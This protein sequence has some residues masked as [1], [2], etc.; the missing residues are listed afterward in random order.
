MLEFPEVLNIS[1]QLQETVVGKTVRSVLPP[2]KRHKFC[3]FNGDPADYEAKIAGSKI[4]SATGFGMF[5]EIQFENG[6]KLCIDD[7]VNARF[8]T[9]N[10]TPGNFQLLIEFTDNTFLVFTVAMYGGIVLHDDLYKNDYYQKS[11]AAVS[12]LSPGFER[13]FSDILAASKPNLSIK[14]FIATEQRFPGIGN[15]VLQDILFEA[16][17]HPKR[18]IKSLTDEEKNNLRKSI[19]HVLTEMAEKGGRDTEKDI[20]GN[21]CS[22]VTRLSKNTHGSPCPI[23]GTIIEKEQYLGGVIYFCP[24]CQKEG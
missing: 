4:A 2:T 15:G 11:Q 10:E 23:C 7:G 1:R 3:W 12:P 18:K 21:A 5:V 17:I 13:Y 8:M 9:E 6:L 24:E 22:Y 19:V 16:R 20:F 14:A